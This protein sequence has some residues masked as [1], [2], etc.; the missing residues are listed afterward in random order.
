[1]KLLFSIFALGLL[2]NSVVGNPAIPVAVLS[3][4]LPTLLN[5]A[6]RAMD[7]ISAYHL[8]NEAVTC[9]WNDH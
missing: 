2:L 7:S 3:I 5:Q 9:Y 1:M 4:A 8:T 6:D